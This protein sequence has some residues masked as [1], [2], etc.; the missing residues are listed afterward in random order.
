MSK[1]SKNQYSSRELVER[2]GRS[3]SNKKRKQ[4]FSKKAAKL[5]NPDIPNKIE[6]GLQLQRAKAKLAVES[7]K[8]S[9]ASSISDQSI[10]LSNREGKKSIIPRVYT[11]NLLQRLERRIR[12]HPFPTPRVDYGHQTVIPIPSRRISIFIS[13]GVRWRKA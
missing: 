8:K 2:N 4:S 13:V 5:L 11:S 3:N 12:S 7:L 10:D 9:N 1:K 6:E